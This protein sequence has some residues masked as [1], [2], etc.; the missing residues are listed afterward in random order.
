MK[1]IIAVLIFSVIIGCKPQVTEE[2]KRDIQSYSI[3]QFYQNEN[4]YAG[5]FSPDE[6]KIIATSNRTGIYNVFALPIDGSDPV[7]LTN[8]TT[9]SIFAISYF[10]QDD[11]I[12]YSSDS[13]GNEINHIY[14][15]NEDGRST[16]LTPWSGVKSEFG[17]WARDEKNF[18]FISNK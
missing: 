13:G 1:R 16:D 14:V 10:P 18:F 3:D 9:E 11:R 6:T 7:K 12:L 17:G 15:R 8:S 4:V 5:G 2:A